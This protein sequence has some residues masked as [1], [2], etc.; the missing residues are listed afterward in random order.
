MK[1]RELIEKLQAFDS[2]ITVVV[3]GFDEAGYADI[4]RIEMVSAVL[5]A[6]PQSAEIIGEYEDARY[7]EGN[8]NIIKLLHV[9]H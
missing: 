6:S 5:R 1:V 8:K 4:Q 9:D 3:G 2:D 7:A